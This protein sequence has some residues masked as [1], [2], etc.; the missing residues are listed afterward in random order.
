MNDSKQLFGD[1]VF[2]KIRAS[3][4]AESHREANEVNSKFRV[5]SSANHQKDQEG[6]HFV[7]LAIFQ[8]NQPTRSLF[9]KSSK[10]NQQGQSFVIW[11]WSKTNQRRKSFGWLFCESWEGTQLTDPVGL[12]WRWERVLSFSYVFL[13]VHILC[14]VKRLVYWYLI[15][16][17][18]VHKIFAF[19]WHKSC[20]HHNRLSDFN[21]T[22]MI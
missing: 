21:N 19:R 4:P 13:S 14:A 20:C 6:Q 1:W 16:S 5:A 12:Y 7:C 22:N 10:T 15:L 3:H 11:K 8:I 17:D 18:V 2:A 9:S